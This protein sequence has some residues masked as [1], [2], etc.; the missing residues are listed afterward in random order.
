L[1]T[2]KTQFRIIKS[3]AEWQELLQNSRY[4]I[5]NVFFNEDN[6]IQ[7]SFKE[8]DEYHMGNNKSN[9]VI[10]SFVTS[11]ARIFLFEELAK[12]GDRLLYF[13]TGI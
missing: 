13:D 10:A 11:H 5:L 7:V 4:E 8:N 12:L 9:V 1:Q 2:N 6:F 3:P